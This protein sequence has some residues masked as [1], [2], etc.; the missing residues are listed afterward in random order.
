[1]RLNKYLEKA[2]NVK[3]YKKLDLYEKINYNTFDLM[4]VCYE[5]IY[6]IEFI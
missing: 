5:R 3:F 2:N 1:M 4:E 6:S